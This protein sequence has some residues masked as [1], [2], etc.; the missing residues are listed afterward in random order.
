MVAVS[1]EV[2]IKEI[3]RLPKVRVKFTIKEVGKEEIIER[4][5]N[6][7]NHIKDKDIMDKLK[8]YIEDNIKDICH[9]KIIGVPF[10]VHADNGLD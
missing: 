5:V 1:Y 9:K 8:M 3:D 7:G 2:V 4:T 10:Y 6:L